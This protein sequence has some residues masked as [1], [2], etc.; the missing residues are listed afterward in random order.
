MII[1]PHDFVVENRKKIG[2]PCP[3]CREGEL[4]IRQNFES[5]KHFLSCTLYPECRHSEPF[6][7]ESKD[8]MKFE[9]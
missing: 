9:F 2:K 7:V 8:Q 4:I 3:E 5:K 6:M 1:L